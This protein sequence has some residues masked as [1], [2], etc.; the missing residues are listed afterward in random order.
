MGRNY[1]LTFS[2]PSA[3][4]INQYGPTIKSTCGHPGS[5]K[6]GRVLNLLEKYKEGMVI[7]YE[8]DAG[9]FL[10]GP[11]M[12]TCQSNGTWSQHIPIC[13]KSIYGIVRV[14]QCIDNRIFRR[15]TSQKPG[16]HTSVGGTEPIPAPF[17]CGWQLPDLFL[18]QSSQAKMVASCTARCVHAKSIDNICGPDTSANQY[19]LDGARLE[20]VL[21]TPIFVQMLNYTF[22]CT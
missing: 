4:Q 18:Q 14:E 3:D 17:G 21:L 10:L 19:V 11:V 22:Q 6:H 12:R 9:Y 7:T 15:S 2:F 13:G 20:S 5:P 1:N 16:S 8:C